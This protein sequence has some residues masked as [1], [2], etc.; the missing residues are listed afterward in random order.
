VRPAV[1]GA[2]WVRTV[3]AA[4]AGAAGDGTGFYQSTGLQN[5]E[6]S[7]ERLGISIIY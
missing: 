2:D 4:G 6:A 3:C 5:L 1:S 7:I